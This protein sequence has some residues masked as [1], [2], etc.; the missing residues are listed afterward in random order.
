MLRL[1]LIEDNEDDSLLIREMLDS[2]EDSEFE[3]EWVDRL[4]AGLERLEAKGID[5]VLLDLS[6]PD[7][8]GLETLARLQ[9]R[10]GRLP[11]IVLTGLNDQK[12]ALQSVQKGAQDYLVKGDLNRSIF[13]RA[14]RYA[15]ERKRAQEQLHLQ[16]QRISALREINLA[17]TSTLDLRGVLEVLMEKIE[18]FLPYA[19]VLVWL[20]NEE[21][22]ELERTACWNLN[23]QEW[24]ERS[25]R[26]IPQLVKTA[27][28][29]KKPVI[30]DNVQADS[31]TVD[32]DF[33]RKNGLIS[34]LGFPLLVRE[35]VLGVLVFLTR[36]EHPYDKDEIEFLS[37]LAAQAG[38]AIH[39]S[40]LYEKT[41]K[42]AVKLEEANK[43]Q[44]DF[45]AMIAHDLRS[46]L[47]NVIA[48][49][50]LMEQELMGPV[51][52]EQ[53]KWL[54]RIRANGRKLV[55]LTSDFLD[56]SKLEA[57]QLELQKERTDLNDLLSE[58]AENYRLPA[59]S[60]GIA[61]TYRIPPEVAPLHADRRRLDQV[62]SNL[63]SNAVKFTQEGG[64]IHVE[65]CM[66]NG[67]GVSIKVKDSGVGIPEEELGNLFQKYRRASSA[68]T[69]DHRGIGLGLV[70]CKRIVE[71]HG[72]SICVHSKEGQGT[73]FT[74]TI[75][76]EETTD[77]P[78]SAA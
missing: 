12:I 40:Q 22:G 18:L 56:F 19:A 9:S 4:A 31:R 33:Y 51:S 67:S 45:T 66:A 44:A 2:A 14:V 29:G 54:E 5:L 72:G 49:A 10:A 15:L 8:H 74:F 65:V 60:K 78:V 63:L 41:K 21:T 25:L 46:P 69:S 77:T 53:R 34:Y 23:E 37:S 38:I 73:T 58:L 70:I 64:T 43:L 47:M 3:I 48:A 76:A 20:I 35:E 30:A 16:L 50:E 57:G 52:A 27:A 71:A 17:I 24:I 75:P 6:L 61:L 59:Q 32:P 42:Q 28:E 26:G 13:I 39:N 7:S 1:L 68:K 55:D 62:L 36:E 11:V